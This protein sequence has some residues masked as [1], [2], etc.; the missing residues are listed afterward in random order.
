M[1]ILH[2]ADWHLGKRLDGF[3]RLE[4]QKEVLREICEIAEAEAVDAVLIAGDLFDNFNPPTEA[5]DLFYK[6]LKRL[7]QNGQR[8]VI[9]IAGNHDSPD[10]IEA[11]DPLARECG[12][13]FVGYPHSEINPFSLDCNLHVARSAPGFIELQLPGTPV[14]LRLLLTAYANEL[15]LKTYLGGK[16]PEDGD[17][18]EADTEQ[19]LRQVLAAHWQFLADTYCDDQGVNVLMAHLYVMKKDGPA[20]EEPDDE[21]PIAHV[22]GAQAVFSDNV[23]PQIQ[24]VAL[25]HLHRHQV[26]D[27]QPCPVVYSSSPLAY[28]FSEA[29]QTKYVMLVDVQPGQP[30]AYRA[31]P[32]E[33]GKKLLRQRF[34][35]IEEAVQWLQANPNALVELTVASETYLTAPERKQLYTAHRGIVALIPE[36][37]SAQDALANR[38]AKI[39]LSKGMEELFTEFF[40]YKHVQEPNERLMSLFREALASEEEE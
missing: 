16:S 12:I 22:G 18:D 33:K 38:A 17:A 2:T 20:P 3:S 30:A 32:L 5:T 26:I 24:Y 14:P 15:R 27:T 11:P 19:E 40:R 8:P 31:I 4:E 10:R 6:T 28:S 36:V 35:G 7:A 1:R 34:E 37:R 39:D 9:A 21:R 29:N 25:G 23:P 13:I